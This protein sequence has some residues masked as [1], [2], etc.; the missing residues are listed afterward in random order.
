MLIRLFLVLEEGAG[1]ETLLLFESEIL[2]SLLFR[3]FGFERR[4]Q[5][6][7]PL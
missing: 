7:S 6:I 5:N 1:L 4:V 2:N 3:F